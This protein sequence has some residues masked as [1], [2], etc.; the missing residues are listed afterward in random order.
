MRTTVLSTAL[1]LIALPAMAGP[2]DGTWAQNRADC[3][4]SYPETKVQISGSKVSFLETSCALENPTPIR[5]MPQ[6]KLYDLACSG[7]GMSWS[8]RT[9]IA[10]DGSGLFIFKQGHAAMYL[11]C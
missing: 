7:E 6:G 11:H 8:D 4:G 5:G 10:K 9:F 2:F 1:A 3:S